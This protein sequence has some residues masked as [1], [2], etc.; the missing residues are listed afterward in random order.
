[1]I[2][3][4]LFGFS[5]FISSLS[6]AQNTVGTVSITEEAFEAYTLISIHTKAYLIN[7]C[8]EVINEWN[9]SYLPGNAV[10][11]LPNGNLLRAG[12]LEDGSSNIIFGG[13]GGII[14]LFDWDGN[15][16]WSYT[17][18]TNEFRQHH[19]VF[20]MTNGN[21]LI[22]AATVLTEAEAIAAGRDPN[23]LSQN[24]L[25]NEQIIEVEPIGANQGNIVW[26]WN[27]KDHLIQD[28]DNTKANFG[29]VALTPGK[30]DINFLNGGNGGSNWLHVNS[31]QYDQ[32][33]DQI[34]ISSRNLSEIYIIDHSTTTAEAATDSGGNYGRGGDFLYR[35]GN[36]QTY[37]QGS[38][39]DRVL[40]G[41]HYPHYIPDGLNDAGK[42]MIFNNGN[43]RT[44]E[45][46]EVLIVNPPTSSP[47]FY[48]YT[49][50][51]AY[52]PTSS[53]YSYSDQSTDPSEFYSSILSSAQRLPNGNTLVCEGR[54]GEIFEIDDN[55][56]IVWEY[57]NPIDGVDGTASMQGGERPSINSLFRATKYAPDFPAF[58]GR[59]L[60]PSPP[61]E[62]N[63]NI[64]ACQ[65]LS[66]TDIDISS[67][68]LYPNPASDY[69]H[70]TSQYPVDKLELYSV[71]G[72]KVHE[73]TLSNSIDVSAVK[74]GVYFLQIHFKH[75]RIS[76][77]IIKH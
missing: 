13:L 32:N 10:Y 33:L 71:L 59:D 29:D 63:P 58:A 34:V 47:G 22:L 57:I 51:T 30:L 23:L 56:N 66:T 36:P 76:K 12:R 35:W 72:K 9:S 43:G 8:G 64:T 5:L 62:F 50:N 2:K 6:V 53:D 45:Y 26:E 27:F 39:T 46:S 65:N 48:S 19:D 15:I 17:Y 44:P 41:Q 73:V 21:I 68:S 52:G 31:I 1:M 54:F 3:K 74:S 37:R 49:I 16:I 20:P 42:L 25:F 4:L 60:S 7:N 28:F 70:I 40:Y 75:K 67:I 11:L 77:K 69:I 55:E 38:E 14:E 61:L 18:S 24:R